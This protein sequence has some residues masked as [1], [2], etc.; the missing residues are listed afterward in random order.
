MQPVRNGFFWITVMGFAFLM[1]GYT[2]SMWAAMPSD[3]QVQ[4]AWVRAM[5]PNATTSAAYMVIENKGTQDDRL[6]AARSPIA[7][8]VELHNVQKE[9]DLMKMFPVEHIDVPAS[10]STVLQPGGFH[11]MLIDLK[12]SKVGDQV[13]LV[14]T[15]QQAG[16]IELLVPVKESQMGQKLPMQ[17]HHRQ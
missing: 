9:G 16:D 6:I 1:I 11:I 12:N 2:G 10:G 7:G 3:I 17:H 5:P 8:K 14:L 4:G 13:P 15:F